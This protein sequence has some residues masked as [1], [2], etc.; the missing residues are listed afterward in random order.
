M[1][2]LFITSIIISIYSI[3]TGKDK[4]DKDESVK[5]FK[6]KTLDNQFPFYQ[7]DPYSTKNQTEI[8]KAR[9]NN[10]IHNKDIVC[11]I[12]YTNEKKTNYLIK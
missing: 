11:A 3:V 2:I 5:A 7:S 10:V 8:E 6:A 12:Q 1:K 9:I 4:C